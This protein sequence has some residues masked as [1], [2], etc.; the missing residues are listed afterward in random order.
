MDAL[1]S[2]AQELA[3]TIKDLRDAKERDGK[4]L[5]E[6][7]A[8]M[9]AVKL[10]MHGLQQSQEARARAEVESRLGPDSELSAYVARSAPAAQHAQHYR[11]TDAG[12]VRLTGHYEEVV[13]P[14]RTVHRVWTPGLLDDVEARSESQLR[15]QR[16]VTR[17]SLAQLAQA[18][19]QRGARPFTPRLDAE[20]LEAA[21]AIGLPEVQRILS[22]SSGIGASWVPN[23][24]IPEIEREVLVPTGTAGL[25]RR[26]VVQGGTM[27]IPKIAG[28]VRFGI[29]AAPT[30][31]DPAGDPLSNLTDS[32]VTIDTVSSAGGV[33]FDRDWEEDAIV[34]VLPEIQAAL[35][36]GW[37]WAED[38][39]IIN[40]DAAATH[41]DA[42]A[43]W[44]PR[45]ML[46][47]TSG[48]GGSADHRRRWTGLRARAYDLTSMTTDQGAAKTWAGLKTALGKLSSANMMVAYDQNAANIVVLASWEYFFNNMLEFAEFA[49]WDKVGELAALIT[50][51]IGNTPGMPGGLLPMQVGFI[52]GFIPVCI[53][54]ALTADLAATGLYT[55]SGSTTGMLQLDRSRFEYV[56]RKNL[57]LEQEIDIRNNTHTVVARGRSLFRAQDPVSS[58]IKDV[59]FSFNL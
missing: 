9:E 43:S 14:D 10:A 52:A 54:P 35:V 32:S 17:R 56:I 5:G 44:D 13:G 51:K 28:R 42:I 4:E 21:R 31:N 45:G 16:A 47:G 39:S 26:R 1:E 8:G 29:K 3:K 11:A 27:T 36:A 2:Q 58:S 34:A 23:A 55:A 30:V 25:F 50:G 53:A 38:D 48:L 33:Q 12:A 7:R 37:R 41:Q 57:Q 18:N 15:L 20:V 22:D 46:G 59:H 19:P 40:G 49:S 24:T 6:L